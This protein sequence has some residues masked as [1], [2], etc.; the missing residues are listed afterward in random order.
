MRCVRQLWGIPESIPIILLSWRLNRDQR[1]LQLELLSVLQ[2]MYTAGTI[3]SEAEEVPPH[4]QYFLSALNLFP[5]VAVRQIAQYSKSNSLHEVKLESF[6]HSQTRGL[7][8]VQL[9]SA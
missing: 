2:L 8:H 3:Q 6:E 5:C 4:D 9:Y 1:G 7:P